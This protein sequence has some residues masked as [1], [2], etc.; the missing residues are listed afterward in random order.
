M[1]HPLEAYLKER[2]FVFVY[3]YPASQAA[4]AS[5]RPD[6]PLL[7]RRFELFGKGIELANGFQELTDADEQIERFNKDRQLRADK[8]KRDVEIDPGLIRA[9]R[10]GLPDCAGVALGLDRLLMLLTGQSSVQDVI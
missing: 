9:L 4:L 1:S 3:D 10:T 7:A 6:N 2:D 8:G 5:L